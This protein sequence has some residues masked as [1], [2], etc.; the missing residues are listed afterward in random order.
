MAARCPSIAA[1]SS[2][3]PC[4][5]SRA[6]GEHRRATS[7]AIGDASRAPSM[8]FK[9]A[10]VRFGSGPV[11]L[12]HDVDVGDLEDPGLDRLDFVAEPR[13]GD[14]DV[15]C[16]ARAIS[17]SS[18]PTPTV[19]M[20]IVVEAAAIEN[21]DR[22][23]RRRG[24]ARPWRRASPC[25]GRRRLDRRRA[26][27]SGC[28][29]RGSRRRNMGSTDRSRR[30]PTF[31]PRSPQTPGQHR[32]ERRLAAAGHAGDADDVRVAGPCDRSPPAP[33]RPRSTPASAREISRAIAATSPRA[34]AAAAHDD[35]T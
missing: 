20:M 34:T 28:G 16:E 9:S 22:L 10:I 24:P 1:S 13:R 31:W 14:H 35:G 19:S 27:S 4:A 6:H 30:S 15:V 25:C 5:A 11:A 18:C 23:E 12:R 26:R 17:T 21:I 7:F 8:C 33:P 2:S 3:K 29:R 32:D